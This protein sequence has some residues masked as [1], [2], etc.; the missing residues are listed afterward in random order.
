MQTPTNYLPNLNTH[1]SSKHEKKVRQCSHCSYNTT[2]NTLFL[3]H[4]RSAHGLFQKKS[5]Y[6]VE[7]EAHPILCDDCG[8]STFNQEQFN[9]HK[10][11][12]CQSQPILQY[13]SCNSSGGILRREWSSTALFVVKPGQRGGPAKQACLDVFLANCPRPFQ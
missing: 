12:G 1:A 6:S 5:K 11:N 2:W 13:K 4:M 3:E 10:L 9:A 8:F 7:S